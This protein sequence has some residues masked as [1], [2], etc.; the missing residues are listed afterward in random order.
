MNF[1]DYILSFLIYVLTF[2]ISCVCMYFSEKKRTFHTFFVFLALIVPSITAAFRQSGVDYNTYRLVYLHIRSG[3]FYNVELVWRYLNLLAPSY[4][5]LLFLS[6]FILM[7]VFYRAICQYIKKDRWLSWLIILIVAYTAS[8]NLI[9]Q[10]IAVSIAFLAFSFYINKKR[11]KFILCILAAALFHT[12]AIFMIFI[13]PLVSFF[14]RRVHLLEL[15]IG[16]LS[17]FFVMSIPLLSLILRY[18]GIYEGYLVR[19]TFS[20]SLGFLLYSIPPLYFYYVKKKLMLQDRRLRIYVG[21]YLML[22]PFQFL[23]FRIA[24][25]DRIAVYFQVFICVLVPTIIHRYDSK[26]PK[27]SLRSLYVIWFIIHYIVLYVILNSNRGY[28]YRIF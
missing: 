11:V 28:P 27:N 20:T 26:Y 19:N 23:G 7:G 16:L 24:Y 2:L 13:F 3:G 21:L 5:V 6:E 12:S 4:E 8:F 10:M 9:R 15:F 1:Q 17:I 18:I 25:S 14:S 22:I